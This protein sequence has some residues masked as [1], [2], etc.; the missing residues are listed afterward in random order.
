MPIR[1]IFPTKGEKY[2]D[3]ESDGIR[4]TLIFGGASLK[5]SYKMIKAFLNEEGFGDIP[6]PHSIEDLQLFRHPKNT[7]GQIVLFEDNGYCHNPIKILFPL[8]RRKKNILYLIIYN[9]EIEQ[10]LLRFHGKLNE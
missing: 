8:D 2:Q 4:Y 5:E 6:L 3:G 1:E 9:E 7:K 10:H